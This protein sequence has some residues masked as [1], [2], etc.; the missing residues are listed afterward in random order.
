MRRLVARP[1]HGRSVF[2]GECDTGP[3]VAVGPTEP[4]HSRRH[5]DASVGFPMSA[6]AATSF[7]R[8]EPVECSDADVPEVAVFAAG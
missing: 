2:M 1:R 3:A 4:R 8:Q 5:Q 6:S 7:L